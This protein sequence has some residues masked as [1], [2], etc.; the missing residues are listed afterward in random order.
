MK[1]SD[2]FSK[3]FYR[4]KNPHKYIGDITQIVYRSS[5]ELRFNEILDSNPNV[6]HWTSEQVV[7]PYIK[8][9]DGRVHKYYVDYFVEYIDRN[10]EVQRDLIEIKPLKQVLQPKHKRMTKTAMYENHVHKINSAKWQAAKAY[11]EKRG[12]KFRIMTE[13][14]IFL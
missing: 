1:N 7:V 4:P 12:W 9:T 13:R 14:S 6:I 3:G 10:N 2:N 5:W 8:P 11:A